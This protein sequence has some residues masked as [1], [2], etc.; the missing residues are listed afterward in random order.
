LRLLLVHEVDATPLAVTE[1]PEVA[2]V[3]DW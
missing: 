2:D 3:V 1:N